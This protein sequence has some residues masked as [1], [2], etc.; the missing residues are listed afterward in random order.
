MS[1]N[2]KNYIAPTPYP[3]FDA[4]CDELSSQFLADP[5]SRH[6]RMKRVAHTAGSCSYSIIIRERPIGIIS[7]RQTSNNETAIRLYPHDSI[8]DL[9]LLREVIT[10][11]WY[12][13][14]QQRLADSLWPYIPATETPKAISDLIESRQRRQAH[15]GGPPSKDYNDRAF[16]RINSGEDRKVVYLDWLKDQG[17]DPTNPDVRS[18]KRD[19]FRKAIERR[20]KKSKKDG[21]T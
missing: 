12:Q 7:L 3:L 5:M 8:E 16:D 6:I 17:E 4:I 13:H 18:A 14:E 1:D 21:R 15:P 11:A 10:F 19:A 9:Q 2:E 20:Q